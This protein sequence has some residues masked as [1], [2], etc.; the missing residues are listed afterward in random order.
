MKR[1][2]I[3]LFLLIGIMISLISCSNNAHKKEQQDD[4]GLINERLIKIAAN[5]L[6]RSEMN[7]EGR[8][9]KDTVS[10]D[11]I[12]R[13]LT[14][15][16]SFTD[17]AYVGDVSGTKNNHAH[18]LRIYKLALDY[19]YHKNQKE[20]AKS[21]L[22]MINR[23]IN[24]WSKNQSDA[25]AGWSS[26]FGNP[27]YFG[28]SL[29]LIGKE[30]LPDS[31]WSMA[32]DLMRPGYKDGCCT[33][34]HVCKGQNLLWGVL[35]QIFLSVLENDTLALHRAFTEAI[36][37]IQPN[38]QKG[39][40]EEGI[41][42][43]YSFHQHSE[44]LYSNGYGRVY[45]LYAPQILWLAKDTR[46]EFPPYITEIIS[47]YI[48][49]G[50]RWMRYQGQMDYSAIGRE[51]ARPVDTS[52]LELACKL[53]MEIDPA[54]K[55]QYKKLLESMIS[56]N[57]PVTHSGNK[58]FWQSEFMTHHRP[59]YYV[60]VNISSERL[61]RTETSYTENLKGYY[62]GNG[63]Q[64][65]FRTGD[66]YKDIFPLWNWRRLPGL[67]C[68]QDTA[69]FPLLVWGQGSRN[70]IQ[71]SG[72]ISD[73]QTGFAAYDYKMGQ[74][75]A[76]RS[77]HFF[78]SVMICLASDINYKGDFPLF[79]TVNQCLSSNDIS[80]ETPEG[81]SFEMKDHASISEKIYKVYHDSIGYILPT[82]LISNLKNEYREANW[83]V[84]SLERDEK[85]SAGVFELGI[86]PDLSSED[87]SAFH[88][89]VLPSIASDKFWNYNPENHFTIVANNASCHA[90]Y[91]EKTH[92]LNL[93]FFKKGSLLFNNIRISTEQAAL[94]MISFDG[95]HR[96]MGLRISDP[97]YE[98]DK[99]AL[100]FSKKLE[101]PYIISDGQEEGTRLLIPL[102]QG[103]YR[104]NSVS[105]K[106]L[107]E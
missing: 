31:T 76:K 23:A 58:Y 88:Y 7:W 67:L 75:S 90:V 36:Y 30:N 105:M 73:G 49:K 50:Q 27:G 107:F 32:L 71:Y 78:D 57:H 53:M 11:S 56:P 19:Y 54:K 20:E 45:A 24:Y 66:E 92:Q 55:E 106:Y 34:G 42:Y 74:L 68:V 96:E 62:L 91:H 64:F 28:K 9:P 40:L 22:D 26:K 65:L 52:P 83:N 80:Y 97:M 25:I 37:E 35:P 102:P 29:V 69:K 4:F 84:I 98:S 3:Q 79:Q 101:G 5:K 14:D 59:G 46:F 95:K 48:L 85:V 1:T 17:I 103:N 21:T 15:D 18:C 99:I 82:N 13:L 44:L 33:F 89:S 10:T 60:S 81:V 104:G 61:R 100:S 70:N 51:I 2:P 47:D 93:A 87:G 8:S 39:L 6:H 86:A 12:K 77:W 38:P 72:G 16:G 63:V 43:D 94:L 41:Q